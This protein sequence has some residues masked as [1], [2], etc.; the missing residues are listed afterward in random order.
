MNE[1]LLLGCRLLEQVVGATYT[2]IRCKSL[3]LILDGRLP[4]TLALLIKEGLLG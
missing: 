4:L 2:K 1:L 3:V